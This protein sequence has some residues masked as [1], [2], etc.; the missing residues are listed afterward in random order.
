MKRIRKRR[1]RE[2]GFSMG[3]MLTVLAIA[4]SIYL[5]RGQFSSANLK[6]RVASQVVQ[7]LGQPVAKESIPR[8][9]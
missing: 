1:Y 3:N 8:P 9:S 4:G 7:E 5:A 2:S 6:G